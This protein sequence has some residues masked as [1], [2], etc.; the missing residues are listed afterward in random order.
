M[1]TIESR[2]NMKIFTEK[3]L[4]IELNLS[5]WTIRLW[6]LQGMPYVRPAGRIFYRMES[7]INWLE[8]E[9]QHSVKLIKSK[10]IKI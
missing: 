1:I 2:R 9:E 4:A 3:E 10:C 6:R 8:H 5:P 7:V